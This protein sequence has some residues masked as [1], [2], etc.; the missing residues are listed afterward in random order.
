MKTEG[1]CSFQRQRSQ[2]FTVK[3]LPL[4]HSTREQKQNKKERLGRTMGKPRV[5][6]FQCAQVFMWQGRNW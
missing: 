5:S 1:K 4:S 2:K 6:L 3:N